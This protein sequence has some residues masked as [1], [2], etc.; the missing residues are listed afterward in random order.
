MACTEPVEVE[1]IKGR[2]VIYPPLL[3]PLS[4]GVAQDLEPVACPEPAEGKGH[5]G[6]GIV[7]LWY[8]CRLRA[9]SL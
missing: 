5:Q 4:F 3:G 8:F 9:Q 1:G 6:R 7:R 2:V